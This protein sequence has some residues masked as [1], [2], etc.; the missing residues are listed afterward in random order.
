MPDSSPIRYASTSSPGRDLRQQS[1]APTESSGLFL[2]STQSIPPSSSGM[3]RSS[4]GDI[5]PDRSAASGVR[6]RIF[7]DENGKVVHNVPDGSDAAT[8][9]NNDPTTSDADAL[10][11]GPGS[12]YNTVWGTNISVIDAS[13]TFEG[14]L[15]NFTKKYRMW[16][17]GMTVAE[18]Q[19]DET[20]E[21]KVYM[22]K[23]KDMLELAQSSLHIDFKDLKAYPPTLKLHHQAQA[24]PQEMIPLMDQVVHNIMVQLAEEEVKRERA[25]ESQSTN[26]LSQT[27]H[28]PSS[29]MPIPSSD[30][31]DMELT[32]GPTQPPT[33][34]RKKRDILAEVDEAKYKVRLFGIESTINLRDLD[35]AGRFMTTIT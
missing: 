2:R 5:N 22:D 18:T 9:S 23:M 34:P 15:R 4:R 29:D 14:F 20:S 10:G 32:P 6:R 27:R 7:L 35:P 30:R 19:E 3:N 25:S 17:D 24:Y 16:A 28:I 26:S 11:G 13:K 21:S 33:D 8:F 31:G 12:I 1:D